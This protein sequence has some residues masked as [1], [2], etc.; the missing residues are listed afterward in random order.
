[1]TSSPNGEREIQELIERQVAAIR[2]KDI[3]GAMADVGPG[4]V[5]FDA[6]PP[7]A[8]S[9]S[10]ASRAKT[11]AWF[12]LYDGAIG[13]EV[14]DLAITAG[15]DVGFARYLYRV[16]GTLTAGDTVE[17]WL[18]MTICLE[19]SAGRWIIAHEHTSVP[20]DAESGEAVLDQGP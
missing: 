8:Q 1:M 17:M 16:T 18:R 10:G 14:R 6:L 4:V 20:F 3:E 5:T 11:E 13:Y 12:G 9:G 2:A 7:L 19:R 15:E